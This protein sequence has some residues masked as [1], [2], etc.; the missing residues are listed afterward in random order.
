M[1][2]F[3]TA[4][5]IY[6]EAEKVAG[7]FT[8]TLILSTTNN[9]GNQI[10]CGPVGY[11]WVPKVETNEC[12]YAQVAEDLGITQDNEGNAITPSEWNFGDV[13]WGRV[14]NDGLDGGSCTFT[15]TAEG[16]RDATDTDDIRLLVYDAESD[17][18]TLQT[19]LEV[20]GKYGTITTK[21]SLG[22]NNLFCIIIRSAT[23]A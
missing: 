14:T 21:T 11:E 15:C 12:T 20:D 1:I 10:E 22:Y 4:D 23:N 19:L 5:N 8:G 7:D 6:Y 16:V 3:L 9:S 2:S 17:S 13:R 18:M